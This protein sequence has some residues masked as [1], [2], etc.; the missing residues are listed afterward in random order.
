MSCLLRIFAPRRVAIAALLMTLAGGVLLPASATDTPVRA[1][2]M[3]LTGIMRDL[4]EDMQAI[5]DAIAH[6]DWPKVATIATRIA[7]HPQ[8]PLAEKLRILAFAGKDTKHFR[9]YDQQAH[10]AAQQ[11]AQAAQRADGAATISAFA[12]VQTACLGCHQQF[13]KSF[14]EHFHDQH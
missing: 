4:G 6:E 12:N 14:Q 13:R 8:P 9:G 5:T 1:T 3:A 2:P 11:L 7:D 10:A